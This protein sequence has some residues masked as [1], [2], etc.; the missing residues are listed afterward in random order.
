MFGKGREFFN[1]RVMHGFTVPKSLDAITSVDSAREVDASAAGLRSKDVDALWRSIEDLFRSGMHPMVGFCLR[2]QGEIVLNRSI[3]YVSGINA[4]E[5]GGG[6]GGIAEDAVIA[7]TDTP[8]CLFSASKAITAMLV[9]KAAEDG[10]INLLDPVSYYIPEFAEHGKGD[11]TI[12]H[13]LSHRAGVPTFESNL[14]TEML[15]DHDALIKL[16]CAAKPIDR[17]GRTTAYHALTGGFIM[18]ELI[19]VA[20][21][22][23]LQQYLDDV[24]RKPMGMKYFRYGLLANQLALAPRHYG[25]GLPLD[26]VIGGVLKQVLGVDVPTVVEISNSDDFKRAV[27]PSANLYATAEETCRFFQMMLDHGEYVDPKSGKHRQV[28]KPLAVHR[29]TRETGKA[30]IDRSL[31]M[32]MR[33][34]TG[35]MLGGDPVG[36]YGLKTHYAYGHIGFSNVLCWADPQ[37]DIS[38]ALMTS[39]KPVLGTHIPALLKLMYKISSVCAP[40]V[41]MVGDE[42]HYKKKTV[43]A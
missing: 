36:V 43:R 20:T 24:I 26:P 10:F 5:D 29:A 42:P 2:R 3:G 41:D 16:I 9:H 27:I 1:R 15:F 32:P 22:K 38:V 11:I 6:E 28:M 14:P 40:C 21:G 23:T 12:W 7:S 39:G 13:L 25:T 8:V 31:F 4:G 35:M 37:R 18:A 17:E 33:Y 19:K 30:L 34:S